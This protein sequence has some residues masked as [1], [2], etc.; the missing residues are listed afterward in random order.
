MQSSENPRLF[1]N[2]RPATR[3]PRPL[4]KLFMIKLSSI[5]STMKLTFILEISE[6]LNVFEYVKKNSWVNH[7]NGHLYEVSWF[8]WFCDQVRFG[9]LRFALNSRFNDRVPNKIMSWCKRQC[10]D[11]HKM[12][13]SKLIF[14]S[15]KTT[16]NNSLYLGQKNARIQFLK[17]EARRETSD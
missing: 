7:Q 12:K 11:F 3:D 9:V 5:K 16:I 13:S 8:S 17:S 15:S 4:G 6:N 1:Q 2:P 10:C 14:I